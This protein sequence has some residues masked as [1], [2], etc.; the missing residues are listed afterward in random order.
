ML[1][2]S[3][4][5]RMSSGKYIVAS[6]HIMRSMAL[7]G[8]LI[9]V[10]LVVHIK[11][12]KFGGGGADLYT[13][14]LSWFANPLY[15]SF[16]VLALGG[17]ALHL[18]HGVQ[19]ALQTF[20]LNHPRY[21]PLIRKFGLMFAGFIFLGFASMPL[22]FGF[23]VGR[24]DN[25]VHP[26]VVFTA[27]LG[28]HLEDVE[29]DTGGAGQGEEL[30]MGDLEPHLA[31][32]EAVPGVVAVVGVWSEAQLYRHL[33]TDAELDR[34]GPHDG[35]RRGSEDAAEVEQHRLDGGWHRRR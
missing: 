25:D 17:L 28:Q 20:G 27:Q 18:S 35:E 9:L 34:L 7:T 13:H 8:T 22:Y 31:P 32:L 10:F 2:R 3:T 12:F 30:L 26:V 11:T 33:L 4:F 19:S 14:V 21:T 24:L 5:A 15:A 29:L 23:F 6:R 1:A 16:Y